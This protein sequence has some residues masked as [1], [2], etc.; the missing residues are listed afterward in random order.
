VPAE[1]LGAKV[2]HRHA[3]SEK[4]LEVCQ[5]EGGTMRGLAVF[6]VLFCAVAMIAG[7]TG[8][9][10]AQ[11]PRTMS[12]Q[13]LLKEVGGTVVPDGTYNVTFRIYGLPTGG[14]ALWTEP[15][16]V[17]LRD[18]VFSAV[19]G[20][21]N[22]LDLPF[23]TTYWIS[24]EVEPDPELPRVVLTSAPYALRA[25][26]ADSVVGGPGGGGDITAVHADQG[27]VGGAASGEAHLSV[28]AGDGIELTVDAVAVDVTPLA[29]SGLVEE[30][31]NDLAVNP[32]TGLEVAADEVRLT[33][34]YASGSVYDGRFVNEGQANSVT[35][36]MVTPNI[37]SSLDGVNNDGGNI[38][39]VAGQ[40]ITITPDNTAKTITIGV[41]TGGGSVPDITAV[42]AGLGLTGGATSGD[43]T[44]DVGAGDGIAVRDNA[45]D[46]SVA[47]FAGSGL[48]T[49][50]GNDLMV[51]TGAGL[52]VQ[53]DLVR[54]TDSYVQG[55]AYDTRFVNEG[56]ANSVTAGMVT[57]DMISSLSG[58]TNDAGNVQLVAGPNITITPDDTQ[59]TITI[60]A[61]GGVGAD[62][63]A[64]I[65][66]DGLTGGAT[67]GDARLD[68]GPGDGIT[69]TPDAIAVDVAAFAGSGLGVLANDLKV[70]AGTGLEVTGDNVGLTD[71]Y[72]SGS[73]HD[74][75]FVNE[76][77]ANSVTADMVMPNVVG[78][79]DG[80]TNDAGNIDLVPGANITITPDDGNNTITIASTGGGNSW[81]AESQGNI[82]NTNPGAVGVG[83]PGDSQYGVFNV[84]RNDPALPAAF[85]GNYGGTG[86]QVS[87]SW[88]SGGQAIYASG[89]GTGVAGVGGSY[90]VIGVG[91]AQVGVQGDGPTGVNGNGTG[92]TGTGVQGSGNSC[93]VRGISGPGTGVMGD[94]ADC[95]VHA[96]SINIGLIAEGGS[97]GVFTTAT[98]DEFM[99]YA[100][101]AVDARATG[102]GSFGVQAS[103][104]KA[105]VVATA[106]G[107][108]G[109]GLV[110]TGALQGVKAT[111]TGTEGK[112]LVATAQ[113]TGG[114][115]VEATG[116]K[117][118]VYAH[119]NESAV[120]AESQG[121]G[122]WASSTGANG[123]G[124]YA[125]GT[126]AA[127][128]DGH[129][130]TGSLSSTATDAY[131]VGV[132]AEASGTASTGL[133]AIGTGLALYADAP[134]NA[135]EFQGDVSV[136][137]ELYADII[138]GGI[139]WFRIDHPLDPENK[140]L[141][142]S[143]VESPDT[144]NIYDG[145]V[146]LDGRGEA[147]VALPDWFGALNRDFRYQ[148]TCIGG[149]ASVY[150]AEEIRDNHFRIA[151]GKPGLKVSWQV[152]G[153]RQDRTAQ[154]MPMQVEVDKSAEERGT[155]L[156]AAAWGQP[157][158]RQ[159]DP[160]RE[161]KKR[162]M[163][164]QRQ[165]PLQA[166]P[167]PGER[168]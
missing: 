153:I 64:V 70:N 77:Q 69:V 109:Q 27:L 2:Q 71:P 145:T 90:G 61:T 10:L 17:Q 133:W 142:H 103:G 76:G 141:Q 164:T 84:W 44:L 101:A 88:A 57:P 104:V 131:S 31:A 119:G 136:Y 56:Q 117:W 147:D 85:I 13:G 124:L 114:V 3:T 81:W 42:Y 83:L 7:L 50:G 163:E 30:G 113:M 157:P 137:G 45:V 165:V 91:T 4:D 14:E 73:A 166:P 138:V 134:D 148:L 154:T 106:T 89:N 150:V 78:S 161:L 92:A 15:Q 28:G 22:V 100:P 139:K 38:D 39:L 99:G 68:V 37:V 115:A 63:T 82:R 108:E 168:P 135:A 26:V 20:T 46:V 128:L 121:T 67:S 132:R 65:A 29:G 41:T 23:D 97:N 107:A 33:D 144:K 55:S 98:A 58:V 36:G 24:I 48:G 34:P 74:G 11:A 51:N 155:Y 151:G 149:F 87:S 32:G 158:E 110:A 1:P 16:A 53:S 79:L 12:Y 140:Y 112:G 143:C 126:N 80:V 49:E 105:G 102:T 156:D 8:A 43:A 93:G 86:L 159:W 40:Y 118:G 160:A 47:A 129:V 5:E 116:S 18:G 54:L 19:L 35:L 96:T 9:A 60:G 52:T 94:G 62:I 123:T 75:R 111:A 72:S 162:Q 122:V 146:V 130:S 127:I 125:H 167:V 120:V 152:T 25:A 6:C 66:G 59:N 95:G 21:V